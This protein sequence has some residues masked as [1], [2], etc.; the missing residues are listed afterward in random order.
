MAIYQFYLGAV[1][2][3]A[4]IKKHGQ[5]PNKI[6]VSTKSGY[7]ESDIEKY[8]NLA[9]IAPKEIISEIDKIVKRGDWGGED[10]FFHEWKSGKKQ[11][12]NDVRMDLKKDSGNIEELYFRA[13]LREEKL[14]FLKNMIEQK[15]DWLF[16]DRKG[17]IVEPDFSEVSKRIV[18]SDNF[19]FLENPVQYLKDLKS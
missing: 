17:I 9:E 6:G 15:F 8:W 18:V 5:I 11:A 10:K 14:V 19:K 2:K 1:P 13:D 12:D 7:F 16:M 3:S 4:L